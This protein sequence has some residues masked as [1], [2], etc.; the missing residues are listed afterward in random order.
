MLSAGVNHVAGGT[1]QGLQLRWHDAAEEACAVW[2]VAPAEESIATSGGNKSS[3]G[4]LQ[5]AAGDEYSS[6]SSGVTQH[7]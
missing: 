7:R 6:M 3:S 5:G 1:S 2:S 4:G